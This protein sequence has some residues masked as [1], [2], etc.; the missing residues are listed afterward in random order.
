MKIIKLMGRLGNQM[1]LWAFGKAVEYYTGEKVFFDTSCYDGTNEAVELDKMFNIKLDTISQDEVRK[2][3]KPNKFQSIDFINKH[4]KIF[5]LLLKDNIT[6]EKHYNVYEKSLLTKSGNVC[7]EGYFQCE[8]YFEEIKDKIRKD[9]QFKQQ[10]HEL[11]KIR[12]EIENIK[13][14]VFIHIRRGDYVTLDKNNVVHWLC[15]MSYYQKAT[16]FFKKKYPDCTFIVFSD[17]TEWVT[18]NLKI[19]YPFKIYSNTPQQNDMYLMSVCK[20]GICANSSYS[21]WGAWLIDNPEKTIVAPTPWFESNK[22]TDII[23]ENWITIPRY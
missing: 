13:C 9:F 7:Y 21:W 22:K 8:K 14:P 17:D 2:I 3:L 20:H 10:P 6:R 5:K 23:P 18:E 19:D 12:Q 11:V 4:K 16:S 15:D 1:F